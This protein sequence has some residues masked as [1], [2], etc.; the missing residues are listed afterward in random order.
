MIKV[1]LVLIFSASGLLAQQKSLPSFEDYPVKENFRGK[2]A[3]VKLTSRRART[4]RTMLRENAGK[5]VN[6]AGHYIAATWGC[7]S[8]C[9]S[10]AIIDARTGQVYFIPSLLNVGGFGYSEEDLIQFHK[11]S[12]L[13]IVVG[14][15]NDEGYVGRYYYVW[16]NNRLKLIRALEDREWRPPGN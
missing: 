4:F 11:D 15:P 7:G 1:I 14:V 10:F 16:K 8:S 13:L 2:S 9:W 6:F 5:E 12:R 3:P